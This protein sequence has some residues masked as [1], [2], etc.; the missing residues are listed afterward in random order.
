V[1]RHLHSNHAQRWT[2]SLE[3]RQRPTTKHC[4][5]CCSTSAGQSTQ[6][7][8]RQMQ[9]RR[10]FTYVHVAHAVSKHQ[11]SGHDVESSG[12]GSLF[13]QTDITAAAHS[14]VRLC[15]ATTYSQSGIHHT[16]ACTTAQFSLILTLCNPYRNILCMHRHNP[17]LGT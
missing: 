13:C 17:H 15:R 9:G 14:P 2:G 5:H 8:S 6:H 3:Q 1:G 16:S 7:S 11:S 12:R 10:H 4:H